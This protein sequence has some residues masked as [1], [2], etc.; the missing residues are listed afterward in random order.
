MKD[1]ETLRGL[2]TTDEAADFLGV[3]TRKLEQ[4]RSEGG[5][6]TYVKLG[7]RTIRYR[8]AA[9]EGWI[10]DHEQRHVGDA[11]GRDGP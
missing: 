7:Y 5:G 9:L 2:L 8:P 10:A 3:S 4:L 6:P 11:P 1:T